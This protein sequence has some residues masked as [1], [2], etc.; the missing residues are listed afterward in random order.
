[1]ILLTGPETDKYKVKKDKEG[2]TIEGSREL[3]T[4]KVV[5][6]S[7]DEDK[8]IVEG[9]HVSSKHTKPRKQGDNGGI[10]KTETAVYASKVQ[11]YCPKCGKGVRAKKKEVV[12]KDDKTRRVRVCAK[13]GHEF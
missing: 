6:V 13:C 2:K 5:A 7:P 11:L 9:I 10:I 1:V 12:G 4:G 3:R 8:V